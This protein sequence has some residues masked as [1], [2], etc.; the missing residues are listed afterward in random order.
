MSGPKKDQK[1]LFTIP[2]N[3]DRHDFVQF[4][5][6]NTFRLK[7]RWKSPLIFFC[8]M[9]AFAAVCFA[10]RKT[11]DQAVLLGT[12]L[13]SVGLVLPAA[14]FL[15]FLSS[16]RAEAK[17]HGL[18]KTKAQYFTL[19]SRDSFKVIRDKDEAAFSWADLYMAYRVKGCIY[20]YA[21]ADRA[22][23]LPDCE[24]SDAAWDLIC[25]R[26]PEEKKKDLR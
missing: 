21:N 11:H 26:L 14:W 10:V 20:L 24:D 2:A 19:L 22:Y 16:V 8:I 17:K 4:A 25:S 5:L 18:S 7:K 13:L 3:L 12:V 9:A 15:M 6:F 1:P 23:L